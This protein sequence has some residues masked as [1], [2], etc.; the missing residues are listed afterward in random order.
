MKKLIWLLSLSLLTTVGSFAEE[1]KT[2]S[3]ESNS[4]V[5]NNKNVMSITDVTGKVMKVEALKNGLYF[6]D[7]K[8][9]V[10]FLEFF[11]HRCPP[12]KKSIPH[13]ID[14][15]NKFKDKL[16]IIAIEVQGLS[17]KQLS[18]F[19]KK[20]GINYITVAQEDSQILLEHISVRANWSGAIPYLVILDQKGDVQTMQAGL[21]PQKPLEDIVN[22][23]TTTTVVEDN[24]E[25]N[26]T[27]KSKK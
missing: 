23:L 3:A 26:D 15:Q 10:I 25:T 4:T 2:Q 8:D 16:A 19:A 14:L 18:S 1:N 27:N 13:Y 9:K 17:R 22:G 24:N 6:Q 7:F 21:I 20:K 11:G 5:I 12:C